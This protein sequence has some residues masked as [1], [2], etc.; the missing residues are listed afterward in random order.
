MKGIFKKRNALWILL[1]A[2]S[3][4]ALS[5]SEQKLDFGSYIGRIWSDGSGVIGTPADVAGFKDTWSFQIKNDE[6]TDEKV[7]TV[8]KY[9]FT[10]SP[11]FGRLK[12][13]ADISLWINFSNP[14]QEVLCLSG[15]DYPG[16]KGMVRIDINAPIK[17]SEQ[18]C[19]LISEAVEQQL[20]NGN[21]IVLRGYA[22][23]YKGGE[24]QKISLGGYIAT[25]TFLRGK[26]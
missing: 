11:Q 26:R 16:M 6:M 3:C 19:V 4:P 13:N 15:H 21:T 1:L 24:T 10:N 17:T 20:R 22:W 5:E 2:L 18:G 7:I 14:E 23:P 8:R 12:L 9:A 25:S